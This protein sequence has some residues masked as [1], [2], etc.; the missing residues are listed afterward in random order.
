[1]E[2][3]KEATRERRRKRP[4]WRRRRERR[5]KARGEGGGFEEA[6]LRTRTTERP[7]RRQSARE[8]EGKQK[9]RQRKKRRESERVGDGRDQPSQ[10]SNANELLHWQIISRFS[11]RVAILFEIEWRERSRTEKPS[12]HRRSRPSH[13][14]GSEIHG[15]AALFRKTFF[16]YHERVGS[17]IRSPDR[18][19][20]TDTVRPIWTCQR[21]LDILKSRAP[22]QYALCNHDD[23]RTATRRTRVDMQLDVRP[24]A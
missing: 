8:E 22:T 4:S 5:E 1:M 18:I 20:V 24:A 9:G 12:S 17:E 2:A 14:T 23:A 21:I 15:A 19:D 16:E 6:A 10:L 11:S 7:A 13:Q 3:T